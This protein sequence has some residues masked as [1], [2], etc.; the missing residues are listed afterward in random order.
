MKKGTKLIL[1]AIVM[2]VSATGAYAQASATATA[3]ATIVTPISIVKTVDMNFGNVAVSASTAGTVVLTPAGTRTSTAGVTLPATAGT[4]AAASFTV[5][6][7]ATYTYAI[8]LPGTALTI[9]NGANN[10]SVNAFSSTPSATGTL[11]AGGTQTLTVGATLNVAAAQA[12]GVYT[13][14]TPFTV[15]VNYN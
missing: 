10:M 6:G 13:S 8:T 1:A 12:P 5:S 11:S 3:T 15:T 2:M 9:A 14:A 4:V 7:Q